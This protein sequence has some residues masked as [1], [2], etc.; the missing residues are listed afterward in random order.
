MNDDVA[1]PKVSSLADL[2]AIAYQI[3]ADAVERYTMLAEQMETHNNPELVAV[4]RELERIEGIHRDEIY[5]IAADPDIVARA[6]TV[7]RWSSGESPES[8]DL[9]DAH[10]LM[11]PHDAL[12]MALAGEE[13]ALAFY[14]RCSM[15]A[16]DADISRLA[17]EFVDEETE[18]VELCHRLL[19]RYPA[20]STRAV[21]DL[22][23]PV[24]QE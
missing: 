19:R 3:E 4:F 17:K 24:P 2:Y 7:A 13:R 20:S 5:R 9:A 14:N 18:H 21:D 1:P 10:Y 22:D 16:T 15:E 6:L 23:P 11:T 12:R 8:A